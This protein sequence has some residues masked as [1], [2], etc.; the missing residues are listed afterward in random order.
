MTLTTEEQ[1]Q[2]DAAKAKFGA[3]KEKRGF[4]GFGKRAGFEQLTDEEKTAL[5]S[6]TDAEKQEFFA[7]KKLEM[8][9]Q[10]AE[11]KNVIDKLIAGETL[12]ASEEATRLEM[13]AKIDEKVSEN[14]HPAREG[15]DIIAKLLA[16]DELTADERTEL[17]NMQKVHAER[18]AEKAK[19]DA[20]TDDEK[21]VYFEA[22]KAEMDAKIE[23]IKPLFEKQKA[24]EALSIQ[25]QAQLDAF[26]SEHPMMKGGRR[27]SRGE[28]MEKGGY[29][30]QED[31]K[32]FPF[33]GA[34]SVK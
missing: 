16:G 31:M 23:V 3:F 4:D 33:E 1:A 6:M 5:K 26:K 8:E 29:G 30:P 2:L 21:T 25:E 11:H 9:G 15:A 22:K 19:I 13:L 7:V 18:E 17:A 34:E 28:K 10:R 12:T 14:N 20:M 27:D 32:E 24:G